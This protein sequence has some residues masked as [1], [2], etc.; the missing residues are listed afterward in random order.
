[1]KSNLRKEKKQMSAKNTLE[2]K[3]YRRTRKA[4][5][6]LLNKDSQYAQPVAKYGYDQITGRWMP[7]DFEHNICEAGWMQ[8][9]RFVGERIPQPRLNRAARRSYK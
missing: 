5:R 3:A 1:L 6:K 2:A 4:T 9:A 7:V 8:I